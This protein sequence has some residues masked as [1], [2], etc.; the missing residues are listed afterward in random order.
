MDVVYIN[1]G[2][3]CHWHYHHLTSFSPRRSLMRSFLPMTFRK[4]PS[5]YFL[6]IN[7][8]TLSFKKISLRLCQGGELTPVQDR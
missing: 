8:S 5:L 3:S 2:H 1:K 4:F 6:L 7:L